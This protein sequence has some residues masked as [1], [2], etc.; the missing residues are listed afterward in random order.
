MN[1]Q[2]ISSSNLNALAALAAA[3]WPDS[4]FAEEYETFKNI[5]DASDEICCLAEEQEQY[6][7][8]I[9]I[10]I[11][12]DY[13]EGAT[14]AQVGY[15]EALYVIPGYQQLGIGKKLLRAGE[16]WSRQKGCRQLAS[17]TELTN[18]AG[19]AFHKSAGFDEVNRVICFIKNI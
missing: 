7:G 9:H 17:D 1:I 14:T 3:L 8:F 13:V 18:K 5:L 4:S 15:I 19:I 11:R 12:T 2:P 16:E 10:S 6:I